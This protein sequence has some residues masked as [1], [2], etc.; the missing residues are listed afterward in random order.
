VKGSA[1]SGRRCGPFRGESTWRCR[2]VQREKREPARRGRREGST[3]RAQPNPGTE[4]FGSRIDEVNGKRATLARSRLLVFLE[5][6]TAIRLF[7]SSSL[8]L[9]SSCSITCTACSAAYYHPAP[10]LSPSSLSGLSDGSLLQ[11]PSLARFRYR[12]RGYMSSILANKINPRRSS[13]S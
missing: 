5:P 8:A 6:L 12:R 13:H 4:R 1:T 3:T 7:V 11:L 2:T 10:C 9:S